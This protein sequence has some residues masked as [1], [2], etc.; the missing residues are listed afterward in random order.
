[1]PTGSDFRRI[2]LALP[3]AE[4]RETWGHPTFRVRDKMF[5]VMATDG[6]SASV[7]ATKEAQAALVGSE[8][9]T[10]SIPAYVGHHGW[11]GVA[12]ARV[13][14]EELRELVT[15]AWLMTVPKRLAAQLEE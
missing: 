10:F 2:A 6:A 13:D 11:V 12:L 9:Q 14:P 8:P 4:E 5:A 3:E 1:V 7:K 15:E